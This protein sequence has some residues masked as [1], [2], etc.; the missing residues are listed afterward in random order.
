MKEDVWKKI[1]SCLKNNKKIKLLSPKSNSQKSEVIDIFSDYI[2]IQFQD[3]KRKL[4]IEK[5]RF[6]SAYKMLNEN[7]GQWVSIGASH[8]NT[9]PNTLEGRIK[10]DFNGNLKGLSTA[11]WVAAILVNDF[12]N[13]EFNDR[14][15]G[16]ALRMIDKSK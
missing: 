2:R 9:K 1:I 6:L 14:N 5:G 3:T 15:M 12:D 13:I 8:D 11:T 7:K 16:K 4:K 10:L